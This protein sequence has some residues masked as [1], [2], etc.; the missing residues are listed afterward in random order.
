MNATFQELTEQQIDE[1]VA[2][3]P[4]PVLTEAQ[5]ALMIEDFADG[6]KWMLKAFVTGDMTQARCKTAFKQYKKY[7]LESMRW[8][9][10]VEQNA[11]KFDHNRG[12]YV[13]HF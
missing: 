1:I 3:L 11:V 13:G 10:W 8:H 6:H 12:K 7:R 9:Q 2:K 4:L 5:E